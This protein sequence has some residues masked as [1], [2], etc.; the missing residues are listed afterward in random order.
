MGFARGYSLGEEA[1]WRE[2][3][4]FGVKKGAS[5]AT[6][7]GFYQGYTSAWLGLLEK[8]E[9]GKARKVQALRTLLAMTRQFPVGTQAAAAA[10]APS[11]AG[12]A[13]KDQRDQ[14]ADLLGQLAKIRAKFKQVH[15]L[16]S[17]QASARSTSFEQ[18][19][20]PQ[21]HHHQQQHA[22]YQSQYQPQHHPQAPQHPPPRSQQR[23][24]M[25]RQASFERTSPMP[26]YDGQRDEMSF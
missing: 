24:F 13:Q 15:Y 11:S 10:Q 14:E 12:E 5:L 3:Y 9:Q 21:Q 22:Q 4:L 8:E 2:G 19:P 23:P 26:P 7:I 17:G 6:E 25:S 20:P 18:Q 16:L 1:G